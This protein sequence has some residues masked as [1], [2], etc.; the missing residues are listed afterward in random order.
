MKK[1]HT[2]AIAG[3]AAMIAFLSS[4]PLAVAGPLLKDGQTV[5]AI[6]STGSL[7]GK[8]FRLRYSESKNML[9]DRPVTKHTSS[10]LSIKTPGGWCNFFASGNVECHNGVGTWKA[11]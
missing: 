11:K 9:D 4:A 10:M 2:L 6:F 7:G 1:H 3:A 5:T 8:T